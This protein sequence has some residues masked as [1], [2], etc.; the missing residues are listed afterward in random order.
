MLLLSISLLEVTFSRTQP[1]DDHDA[2]YASP[3]DGRAWPRYSGSCAGEREAERLQGE[4][5]GI[6]HCHRPREEMLRSCPPDKG[7]QTQRVML[8]LRRKLRPAAAAGG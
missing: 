5:A 7:V 1:Y 4:Q 3:G 8:R 6:V 2:A